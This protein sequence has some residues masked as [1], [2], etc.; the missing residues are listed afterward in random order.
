MPFR[1]R[2]KKALGGKKS[3]KNTLEGADTPKIPGVE[4]YKPNKIPPPR[5]RE[6]PD[7]AHVERLRAFS[8][9]FGR[10]K[11]SSQSIYSP[12]GTKAQSRRASY[13]SWKSK[14][15]KDD[16]SLRRKSVNPNKVPE[17]A[18]DEADVANGTSCLSTL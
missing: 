11:S 15:D 12:S 8:F 6:K 2:M 1:E 10:R 18:D 5:F 7:P 4:Y 17:A 16:K 9:S 3:G 14:S 13:M